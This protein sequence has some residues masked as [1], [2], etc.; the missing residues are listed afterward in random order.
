VYLQEPTSFYYP[1]LP[2]HA[3]YPAEEFPWL[4]EIEAAA[5]AMRAEIEGVLAHEQGVVPYV[6]EHSDRAS[7][8]HSLL[9]DARWS[10]FH[11]WKD[12]ERVEE[13]ARR[14][15]LIMRLL[16]L[17]PIP[18]IKRR[19]PMALISI[20]RPATHIPPHSGMLN[21]RLICHIPL[22]V[23]AGCR[24]RVGAQTRAVVEGKAMLFDDSIEHEAWNDGDAVRAV[25]LFEIW[26]PE[27]CEDERVALTAMFEA[28]TGYSDA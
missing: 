11:L 27:L 14:C 12:G 2:Q 26:R 1:G 16:E 20:L 9:N 15:P 7:R 13:N 10:A 21:T 18:R 8:G 23:P 3:W 19:S 28:V 17:A 4:A 22:V 24:L 6:E 5:P 25:L